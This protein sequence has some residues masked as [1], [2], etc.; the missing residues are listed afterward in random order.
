MQ[1]ATASHPDTPTESPGRTVAHRISSKV[2]TAADSN[3]W[4]LQLDMFADVLEAFAGTA[5]GTVRTADLYERV[6]RR[7]GIDHE[8][9]AAKT[10]IGKSGQPH[11]IAKRKIRWTQQTLRSLGLVERV[12]GSR[13]LWRLTD[14][15]EKKL[16]KALPDVAMLAFSTDLGIAIWGNCRRVFPHLG[17]PITLMITS[18]PFPLRHARAYGN[19]HVSEYTDFICHALE[20]VVANLEPGG[21]IVLNVSNDIFMP[22]TPARSTYLERLTIAI[23]DRLGLSLMD[24]VPWCSNKPPGPVQWASKARVQLNTQVC[25]EWT[26]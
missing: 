2:P 1:G 17:I 25:C 11:S 10:P 16:T 19:P 24:R 18:P 9:L 7:L 13:G 14:A 15:G 12:E 21:S 8:D 3:P 6:A 5:G 20:P 4:N 26:A 23:E 22:G